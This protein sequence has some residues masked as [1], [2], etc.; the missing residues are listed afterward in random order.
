MVCGRFGL[1]GGPERAVGGKAKEIHVGAGVHGAQGTVD[2][3][4]VHAGGDVQSLRE[5]GLKDVACGDVLLDAVGGG[6][7]ILFAGAAFDLDGLAGFSR[8][9]RQRPGEPLFERRRDA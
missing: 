2:L 5:D 1:F 6:A 3:E 9:L 8:D 7:V 4:R